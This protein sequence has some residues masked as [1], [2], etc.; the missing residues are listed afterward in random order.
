M[1]KSEN[2]RKSPILQK[3]LPSLIAI[4][5]GLVIG[6]IIIIATEP[7]VMGEA[8][9]KF[10]L[11]PF[12]Q[13]FSGLGNLMYF[14]MPLLM[15]GLSV[16]FAFQ[17]G[18]FNIG[19]SGQFMV[20]SFLAILIGAKLQGTVP[21]S[22]L[23][24][25]S[26][27]GAAF[28]G[29]IWAAV[30]GI[31]KA[32]RNVNEVITS[33]ML[34]YTGMYLV[35]DFIKR[36][37]VY[38]QMRN[39]TVSLTSSVP[40]FGLDVIFPNSTAGGGILI[41]IAIAIALHILLHRTIKGFEL[42]GVGLNRNAAKYAG[43]NEKNSIIFSMVISGAL[44]G[45]GGGLLYLSGAGNHMSIVNVLPNQGFDGIAIA[46]LGLSEPI[47]V[48]FSAFFISYMKMGG[49][50][51]QTL[52]FAPELITMIISIILYISAL[53]VL[54]NRLLAKRSSNDIVEPVTLGSPDETVSALESERDAA[55]EKEVS[56]LESESSEEIVDYE[57]FPM[58]DK[59][60]SVTPKA[61]EKGEEEYHG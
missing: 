59:A 8:L 34:N 11:G 31:L 1:S 37:G 5:V 42:K 25:L 20:G 17:T 50:A 7:S 32:Y 15:T 61:K 54:F 10:F 29:A 45:I 57:D 38:N 41:A 9:P 58:A 39:E 13:G 4:L 48:V 28:G 35:N 60:R 22:F 2:K 21:D 55:S 16:A 51:I 47:G 3:A 44:A 19:A 12:N 27:L 46:L 14:T 23:W 40:K 33:I 6:V 49:Q 36:F 24:V 56:E 30:V 53:S 18:L 52:G 43:I 26:L